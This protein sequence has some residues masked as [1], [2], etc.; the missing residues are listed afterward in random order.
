M[1]KGSTKQCQNLS[2]FFIVRQV[3]SSPYS[4]IFFSWV[5]VV[6]LYEDKKISHE[7]IP[8]YIFYCID[9]CVHLQL[10]Q[11][12]KS[13]EGLLIFSIFI[14]LL[15]QIPAENIIHLPESPPTLTYNHYPPFLCLNRH[16]YLNCTQTLLPLSLFKAL[17]YDHGNKSLKTPLIGN[18]II[19]FALVILAHWKET[20]G[21]QKYLLFVCLQT[22][23]I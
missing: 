5:W 23:Y 12:K 9:R 21:S 1:V 22:Y 20:H 14:F 6:F 3:G 13:I 16:K 18:R 10:E 17:A 19:S 7:N 8:V 4:L 15:L 11:I 2:S